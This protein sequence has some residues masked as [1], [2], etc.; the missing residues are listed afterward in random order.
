MKTQSLS[1]QQQGFESYVGPVSRI[2][3]DDDPFAISFVI[4]QH[5]LN[6]ADMLH[7]GM[8]MSFASI[9]LAGGAQQAAGS[10]VEALSVNC[11]FTGPGKPGDTV[12]ATTTVT[13]RTRSIVFL[14][15]DVSATADDG[16][17]RML[18]TATGV[19]KVVA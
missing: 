2:G 16:E 9:A 12:T 5:H 14:S 19:Y 18:M 15:C 1:P 3:G 17:S 13:R 11:D 10:S 6:G 7:G 8:M 4:E